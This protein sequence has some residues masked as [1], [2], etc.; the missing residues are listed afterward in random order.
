MKKNMIALVLVLMMVISLVG[1]GSKKEDSANKEVSSTNSDMT[2]DTS[3]WPVV[4]VQIPSLGELKGEQDV[5]KALNEYLVTI[6]AGVKADLLPINFGDLNTQLTL[7][8]SDN[9][10]P[11]DLFCWRFYSNLDGVVKNEQ[12]ISLDS[13]KDQYQEVWELFPDKVLKTQQI[14]G[15]QYALPSVDSYATYE[16][17]MLRKDV[18][19]EIGVADMD[20]QRITMDEMTDI[21]IKAK[22][23]RPEFAYNINTENDP[24]QGIDSLG[25]PDWLGVLMNRGVDQTKIV[26]YYDTA[27]FREY[28][29]RIKGWEK[30]GLL[31]ADPLNTELTITQYNNGVAAGCYVGGYSADYIKAL[32][33]S[34]TYESVQFQL[35]DLVGTSASVLGG[36]GIS[37]VCKNPDAAMKLL[38]LMYTDEK[39]GRFFTLGVEGK[40]YVVDENDC[41]WFPE[42]VDT[43]NTEW[44]LTAPWFY[45]N[46]CLSLPFNT[47]MATYYSDMLDAPNHAQFSNAMGFIFDSSPVY[48][49]VA[50]CTA[51]VDQYRKALMYGQV[52]IEEYLNKFNKELKDAGIDDIIEAEQEQFDRFLANQ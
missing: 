31:L 28:I 52:N 39:V 16:V 41:A 43:N 12:V 5:E 37:T 23:A 4:S 27:E 45:P 49:K 35:T 24:V 46:Q 34:S 15:V 26:N 11:L 3:N 10:N 32:L 6:D 47:T 48:D 42:G 9:K 36:W 40:H 19:E 25:N 20:G 2:N 21:M 18:A 14:D 29:E 1:C 8:L 22:E 33:A 44:N 30:N 13:Y 38:A 17:Y 7:L 50:A 51:I